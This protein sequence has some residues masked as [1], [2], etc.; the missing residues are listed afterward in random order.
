MS[1]LSIDYRTNPNQTGWGRLNNNG[2]NFS[3][4]NI[5]VGR[6]FFGIDQQCHN[7]ETADKISVKFG[8][9]I[10]FRTG[11]CLIVQ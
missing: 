7:V 1:A 3:S 4:I 10:L 9:N 2:E 6:S 5:G 11:S 8:V